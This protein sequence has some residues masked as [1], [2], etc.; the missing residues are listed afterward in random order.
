MLQLALP[1][2]AKSRFAPAPRWESRYAGG[3]KS[4]LHGVFFL[5]P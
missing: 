2:P 3:R 4:L 1:L 5:L